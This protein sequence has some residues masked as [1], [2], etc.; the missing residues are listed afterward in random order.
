MVV[1]VCCPDAAVTTTANGFPLVVRCSLFVVRRSFPELRLSFC[2]PTSGS[3][4]V[5]R[6]SPLVAFLSRR[7]RFGAFL[8]FHVYRSKVLRE[9]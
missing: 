2:L 7:R 3:R 6:G 1:F 9:L 4:L 8:P 5:A